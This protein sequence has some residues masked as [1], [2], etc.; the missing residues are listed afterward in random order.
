MMPTRAWQFSV[1]ALIWLLTYE[2]KLSEP[3]ALAMGASGVF[4][5]LSAI[6]V[7]RPD[8]I[9]PGALALLPTLATCL[10]LWSGKDCTQNA[11]GAFLALPQIQMLGR[12][13]YSWLWHWPVLIIGEQLTAIRGH[14]GSTAPALLVSLLAAILTPYPDRKTYSLRRHSTRPA[15]VAD[16]NCTVCNDSS[17]LTFGSL[18]GQQ[19]ETVGKRQQR[20]YKR[21]G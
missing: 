7:I 14:A 8:A 12:L 21:Y 20:P 4:L 5:L 18:A 13:S 16:H 19:S 1:D 3:K 15:K 6:V 9:Y 17:K 11:I 10:L 2:Q